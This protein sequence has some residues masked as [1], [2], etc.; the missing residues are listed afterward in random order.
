[1]SLHAAIIR[2][3]T[4]GTAK[5]AKQRKAEERQASAIFYR[6]ERLVRRHRVTIKEAAWEVMER[7][8]LAA[9]DNG[10]LPATATQVMYV[11]RAEIQQRT[12]RQ[13]DRQYFNQ[14]VLPEYLAEHDV[15]WDIVFDDRGHFTEPHTK[16]SFGLGTISVRNYL[17]SIGGPKWIEPQVTPAGWETRGP[18]GRFRAVL[19][20]EKEGFLPLFERI[21]L[22]ERFDIAMMSTKGVSVTACRHVVDE[23]CNKNL[24]L[25][26]MHDFDKAGF[27]IL[28]TLQRD[29][30]RYSFLRQPRVID[31][32]LRLDDVRDLGLEAEQTFDRGSASAR[33][34]NLRENGATEEEIEFLL[35]QRVELNALTSDK[36]V[37]WIERKLRAHGVRKVIPNAETLARAYRG[38]LQGINISQAVAKMQAKA[39]AITV[40]ADLAEKVSAFFNKHSYASWDSAI[41]AIAAG[42][43]RRRGSRR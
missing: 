40:P 35:R 14:T 33:R 2:A 25:L 23:L 43:G 37:T 18:N 39:G 12:G 15:S 1:M 7:A 4:K 20:I 27:T 8:Y 38:R 5:W 26:V 24:P 6:R 3:V 41:A 21:R 10:R 30:R 13:L 36:L 16:T 34:F 19:F 42:Q 22:A 9:S 17:N 31:L 32:G 11:A 28:S 29:T